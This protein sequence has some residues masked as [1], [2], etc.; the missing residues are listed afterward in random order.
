MISVGRRVHLIVAAAIGMSLL[1][2]RAPV[3][4]FSLSPTE[5]TTTKRVVALVTGANKG[6]GKEIAKKLALHH[7]QQQQQQNK[8]DVNIVFETVVA[9]RTGSK[10]IAEEISSLLS[11]SSSSCCCHGVYLDLTDESSIAKCAEFVEQRF[12]RLDILINNA[13]ICFN[14]PTLYGKVEYTPF[15]RQ[16]DITIRTN[17]FGTRKLTQAVMPLLLQASAESE[18]TSSAAAARIINIA[19]SA[20]RLGILRSQQKVDLFTNPNLTLDQLDGYMNDFVKAAENGKHEEWAGTCYGMSKLG[21]IAMTKIL[22]RD[23]NHN[24]NN[25]SSSDAGADDSRSSSLLLVN[26][27][28]PGYCA[29]DQNNNQG[30]RPAERGATTPYLLATTSEDFTGM[31][32]FDE[33]VIAW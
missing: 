15:E 6:I 2:S 13:A 18:T 10:E 4:G 29:T 25:S 33:R 24:N 28:D 8:N 26:S 20:G 1:A 9:C 11:S 17:Y 14:D 23:Y 16:A 32:W 5:A 22:A 21:I 27:V 12:G 7:H 19:S 30:T 31:H 3:T